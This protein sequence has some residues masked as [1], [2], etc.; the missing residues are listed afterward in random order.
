MKELIDE[1]KLEELSKK[2]FTLQLHPYHSVKFKP[3]KE[4]FVGYDYTMSKFKRAVERAKAGEALIICARS[5]KYWN[6]EYQNLDPTRNTDLKTQLNENFIEMLFP[7]TT[8]FTP[9]HFGKEEVGKENFK[10]LIE[11]LNKPVKPSL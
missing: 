1:I 4:N 8:Y 11:Y 2:I 3:V 7:R 10:K 6:K 9:K 5:Y